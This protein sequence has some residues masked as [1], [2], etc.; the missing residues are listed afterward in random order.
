M[1]VNLI[2]SKKLFNATPSNR[3]LYKNCVDLFLIF[4][5]NIEMQKTIIQLLNETVEKYGQNPYLYEALQNI[6]YK[7]LTFT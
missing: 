2:R 3:I 4:L 1:R 6:E 5:N 7:A